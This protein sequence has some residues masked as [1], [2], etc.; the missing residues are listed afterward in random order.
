[1]T[2][3]TK[4]ERVAKLLKRERKLRLARLNDVY[5]RPIEGPTD[6]LVTSEKKII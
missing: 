6:R 5:M 3:I 4:I 2:D 1:M